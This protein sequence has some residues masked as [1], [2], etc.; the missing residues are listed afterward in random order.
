MMNAG[1][2]YGLYYPV[3]QTPPRKRCTRI[4]VSTRRSR[5]LHNI[6]LL[7]GVQID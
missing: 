3:A 1:V 5:D 2:A 6:I 4:R 7:M